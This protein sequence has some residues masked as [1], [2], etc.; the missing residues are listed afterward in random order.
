MRCQDTAYFM[1]RHPGAR[2]RFSTMEPCLSSKDGLL[3]ASGTDLR[4]PLAPSRG[5]N[6]WRDCVG[7]MK[8]TWNAYA[9]A[10]HRISARS[11]TRRTQR[12]LRCCTTSSIRDSAWRTLL[13]RFGLRTD[14]STAHPWS[15]LVRLA[16][17][18]GVISSG[19]G[20]SHAGQH[21]FIVPP[22]ARHAHPPEGVARLRSGSSHQ[23]T[24]AVD[25]V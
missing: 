11:D 17:D 19:D 20:K 23:V 4:V 2:L 5:R 22:S 8:R 9:G 18:H 14:F 3:G 24:L 6:D 16:R 10:C 25:R 15:F 21:I 12:G 7:F 13:A 1:N